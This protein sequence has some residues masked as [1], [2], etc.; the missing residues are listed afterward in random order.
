M[1]PM[2]PEEILRRHHDIHLHTREFSDG[3]HS[4]EEVVEYG[5]RWLEAEPWLG[6]S[7]HAPRLDDSRRTD[8]IR[9]Y[10]DNASAW[11]E[12]IS[13]KYGL[14]LLVG[15]EVDW[16]GDRPGIDAELLD[17]LDFVLMAYHGSRLS[18]V[19]QAERMLEQ[20]INHP[21]TDIMA[22]PG[23]FLGDFD[24]VRCDWERLF[25]LMA[26]RGVL[27]EYNLTTPLWAGV[28]DMAVN[29]SGLGFV[30]GSDT[31]DFRRRSVRRIMDAWGE[32]EGG[33][34][35]AAFRYL[36]GLLNCTCPES[37]R[38]GMLHLFDTPDRLAHLENSIYERCR[39]IDPVDADLDPRQVRLLDYLDVPATDLPD[40]RFLVK[41]LER[42][43][44]MPARRIVTSLS[45]HRFRQAIRQNRRRR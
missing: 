15:L 8:N 29:C 38:A 19:S 23:R 44:P 26:D 43:A 45:A 21:C 22:H 39:R 17:R 12:R 40:R 13:N 24:A 20:M 3:W 27:C 37:E 5:A 42:F 18:S 36:A 41:R 28:L 9:R 30:I 35:D 1:N 2:E 33:G 7:D 14:E 25:Q 6:I 32:A 34:F 4:I 10:I 16:E 11:K 31:H